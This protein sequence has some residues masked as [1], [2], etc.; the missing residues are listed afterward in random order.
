MCINCVLLSIVYTITIFNFIEFIPL[1]QLHVGR[2]MHVL[3]R[4]FVENIVQIEAEQSSIVYVHLNGGVVCH[5]ECESIALINFENV[6]L[7]L[8]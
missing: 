8:I 1:Q 4:F 5:Y 6:L 3:Y 7:A 2:Q